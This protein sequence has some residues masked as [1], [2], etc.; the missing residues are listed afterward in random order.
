MENLI[1]DIRY[2][3]RMFA[4]NPGVT[5]VAV[6]TLALG[7]GANTAIFSGVNAFLMRPLPVSNS[8]ELVRPMEVAE[9]R[10]LSDEMSYPDFLDYRNQATSFA[11]LTAEDM[12]QVAINSENQNDVIWGQ[13]VSAS[14]F[15]VM[16][17]KPILGRTFLPDEDT[18]VGGNPAVVLG[19]SF[20][21]RRM[22]SDPNIVGKK[23]QLNNRAYEVIGVSPDYFHGSKFALSMDFWVPISMAEE[24]RRNP[25]VL[26]ERGSHW[27]NVIGRLKPGVSMDQASA[28]M[29]A[30]A[31]R[32][33]Q[34]YPDYRA[35]N[36]QARVL[37]EVEG[38]FE[39]MGGVF[40]S[41]GA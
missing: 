23:V 41:A 39:D 1:K 31:T 15:D 40:K 14:Y 10:G 29:S 20:W 19:N 22:A 4:K 30:I 2:G 34:T 21:Q 6:I 28:E 25:G 18:T 38:R 33:N 12:I 35:N 13:V 5:L 37:G 7:I 9:D 17:V 24:L 36:T 11:G 32:L 3:V 26:A 8:H 16:Q 27:M